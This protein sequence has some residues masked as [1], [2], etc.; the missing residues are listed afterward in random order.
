MAECPS[1][2]YKS[3]LPTNPVGDILAPRIFP[4]VTGLRFVAIGHPLFA[5]TEY[6]Q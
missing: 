6:V 3:P 1:K 4:R 5:A 2:F